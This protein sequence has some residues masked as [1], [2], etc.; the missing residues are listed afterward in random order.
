LSSDDAA[1]LLLRVNGRNGTWLGDL[2]A[3]TSRD[4]ALHLDPYRRANTSVSLVLRRRGEVLLHLL[5]DA[6]LGALNSLLEFQHQSHVNRIDALFLTHPHFDHIAGLDW[7]AAMVRRSDVPG[8]PKP[9]PLYC[10]DGCYEEAIGRRFVWLKDLFSHRSIGS[11]APIHIEGRDGTPIVVTPMA[12]WH[13]PTA[14]GAM[15]YSIDAPVQRKRIVLAWDMLCLAPGVDD[16][17]ARGADL[18]LVDST[19][20]HPQ[21]AADDPT[22][23]RHHNTWHRSIEEWLKQIPDWQPKRTYLIHYSGFSDN[24][25]HVGCPDPTWAT[26]TGVLSEQELRARAR[27]ESERLR[28]DLRVAQHA[29]LIPADEPW[30]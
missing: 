3:D 6:G 22:G 25:P 7:L 4:V 13:G 20:W 11:G 8:Q 29:M 21:Y 19:S 28:V 2:Y 12:V 9:L 10:S 1:E 16:S 18:L 27:R 14:P 23:L 17:P 5:V 26:I 30:P 15:I 24:S